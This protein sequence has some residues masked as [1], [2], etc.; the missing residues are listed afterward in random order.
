M[1]IMPLH[2]C[3]L[4]L[5]RKGFTDLGDNIRNNFG[6]F[7]SRVGAWVLKVWRLRLSETCKGCAAVSTCECMRDLFQEAEE[8][9]QYL[10]TASKGL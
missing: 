9:I 8:G 7:K 3:W 2:S 1:L 6:S 4:L 10:H 5:T